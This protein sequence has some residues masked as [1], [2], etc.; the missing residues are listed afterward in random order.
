MD[1]PAEAASAWCC[2]EVQSSSH[3]AMRLVVVSLHPPAI[4]RL[5]AHELGLGKAWTCAHAPKAS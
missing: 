5:D 1:A 4:S 2:L 3:C